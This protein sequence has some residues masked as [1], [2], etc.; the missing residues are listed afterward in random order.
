VNLWL[1][2][3]GKRTDGYHEIETLMQTVGLAD[4]I[5]L[6]LRAEPGVD[7]ACEPEVC[8]TPKNLAFRAARI[9]LERG[10][11]R[12]AAGL[13]VRVRKRI[14]SGGGLGGG[15][16]DAATVL[17]GACDLLGLRPGPDTLRDW[18]I[19]LGSDVPFFLTGGAAWC[20]GRG[21]QVEPLA[22]RAQFWV[23]LHAPGLEVSTVEVYRALRLAGASRPG[24]GARAAWG[25]GTFAELEQTVFNRLE[26]TAL[27]RHPALGAAQKRLTEATGRP[28][29]LS[30]SGSSLFSVFEK[31]EEAESA[32]HRLESVGIGPLFLLPTLGSLEIRSGKE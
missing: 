29:R 19:E 7:F 14:P 26:G 25:G 4:E 3:L 27:E 9:V 12:G 8:P 6:G 10:G 23:L 11:G 16:S 20:R 22:P 1:E 31:H 24:A 18:A 15:S 32:L 5:E 13:S 17:L 21:E 30:G 28:F 2:V